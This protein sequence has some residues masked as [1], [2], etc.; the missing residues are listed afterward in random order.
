MID[1]SLPL[2]NGLITYPGDAAY[3]E[4][5]YKTHEKDHVHIMRVLMETHSGTHFD[6]PYHMIRDGKRANEIP[7]DK[8]IGP[9]T[10]VQV[11]K[12]R[13]GPEDIPDVHRE[14]II[15]KTPN[16]EKY[17]RFDTS[18]TYLTP[19]GARKLA[20]RRVRLVG[21]DYL[22]IERFGSPPEPL[23]HRELLSRDI[24]I[25]EGLYLKDVEPGDYEL[26]CLPLS[27]YEDG[28]PCRA[29]LRELDG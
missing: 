8:F 19:E 5:Q 20:S 25:L 29:V 26:I 3:E 11:D 9:V 17:G 15:F 21:I 22:S 2:R 23:A 18:F 6:A 24:V 28:A 13:I 4:Y 10:V 1:I 14:R 27:M 16:S 7:L 12:D